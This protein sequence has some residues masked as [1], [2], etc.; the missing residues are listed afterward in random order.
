M[1]PYPSYNFIHLSNMYC[2]PTQN[3]QLLFCTF[4][5]LRFQMWYNTMIKVETYRPVPRH[6]AKEVPLERKNVVLSDEAMARQRE[7]TEKIKALHEAAGRRPKA[8][9]DT[10]G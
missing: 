8:L 6:R 1:R 2:S 10:F 4:L 7:F 9:V 3:L 5:V